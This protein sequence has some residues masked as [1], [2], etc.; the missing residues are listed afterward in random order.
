MNLGYKT[1]NPILINALPQA[2]FYLL[3]VQQPSQIVP[4]AGCLNTKPGT[5]ISHLPSLAV[6]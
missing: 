3:K 4:L 1:S 2:S 5:G 6:K